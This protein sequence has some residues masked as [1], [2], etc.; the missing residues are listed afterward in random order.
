C[1]CQT[2]HEKITILV[3]HQLQY[4]KDA[5]QILILKDGRIMQKGTYA[6]FPKSGVDFEDILLKEEKEEAE[7]SPGPGTPSLRNRTS[8]ESSV[9]SQQ[10]SEPLL[11]DAAHEDEDIENIQVAQSQESCLKGNIGFETYKD[12][13]TDETHWSVI[14]FLTL[15]NIAAQ[16]AYAL[17]DWAN[18][19]SVLHDTLFGKG[20]LIVTFD[21]V[22]YFTVYSVLTVG[23]I[24]FGISGSLL[25]F[26]VLLKS[27]ETVHNGMMMTILKAPV[28]FFDRNP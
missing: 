12:Y 26:Y 17:Q 13:F 19:Q 14:T 20:N 28:L 21:P 5:S 25:M 2:L 9:Q 1:I 3:T 24:L 11:K 16:V 18:E 27:S 4:L 15:V 8:F 22:W 6:E 10:A 23:T 7:L